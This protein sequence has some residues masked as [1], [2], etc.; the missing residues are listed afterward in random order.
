VNVYL[1]WLGCTLIAGC[2]V[3][4]GFLLLVAKASRDYDLSDQRRS[5]RSR[6]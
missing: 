1:T 5:K 3:G 4:F 2:V 6:K